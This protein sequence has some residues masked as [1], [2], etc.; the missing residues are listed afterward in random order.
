MHLCLFFYLT[1]K[2]AY[3]G[4]QKAPA[5]WE[6]YTL[7]E[8][9]LALKQHTFETTKYYKDKGLKI[10]LYEVGNEI[11]F[12]ICGYSLDTK[13]PLPGTNVFKDFAA[14]RQGIWLKEALLLKAAIA[15]VRQADPQARIML[16][17]STTQ[18][19]D[20]V[21]AFFQ[22]M[23]D[24]DVPYDFAGLSYYPWTNCHAEI[25][26]PSNCLDLAVGAVARLGKEA[27]VAEFSFPSGEAPLLPVR[28]LPGYPFTFEGQAKWTHGFLTMAESN[29]HI[30]AVFYFY[31]DNYLGEGGSAALFADDKHPKPAIDEFVEF[32]EWIS[33]N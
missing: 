23:N 8:T 19:P 18:Y 9:A 7:E 20:L 24:F 33:D 1:D 11:E 26:I 27:I 22:A 2:A 31:P 21:E 12:G 3:G 30:R 4:N 15:G 28:E 29:P 25:A 10:E 13:L 17:I 6:K 14:V 16:H 32:Q 5:Q